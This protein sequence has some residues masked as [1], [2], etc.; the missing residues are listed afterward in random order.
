[1]TTP[2]QHA[3]N[4][5]KFAR[6]VSTDILKDYPENKYTWQ[7]S[8]CDNHPLWALV[9]LAQTDAWIAG[10]VGAKGTTIPE[11]WDKIAGQ[12]SKPVND[13]K[14]YPTPTEARKVF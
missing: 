8:P 10:Q 12:G 4:V 7:A 1:M 11:G 6:T 3:I 9:H 13:P 5:L 2:R 14:K